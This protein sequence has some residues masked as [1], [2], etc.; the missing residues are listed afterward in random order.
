MMRCGSNPMFII[1]RFA[2]PMQRF[3]ADPNS[4]RASLDERDGD[5]EKEKLS[6]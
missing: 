3:S 5:E 6:D 4:R 1:A 2:T